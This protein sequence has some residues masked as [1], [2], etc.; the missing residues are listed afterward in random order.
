[1]SRITG[2]HSRSRDAARVIFSRGQAVV[3][4]DK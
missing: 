3:D 2:L 4:H 1:M